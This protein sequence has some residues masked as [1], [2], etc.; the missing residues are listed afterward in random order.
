MYMIN[1]LKS[2]IHKLIIHKPIVHIS[3][4]ETKDYPC[5]PGDAAPVQR[6]PELDARPG[7]H[8]SGSGQAPVSSPGSATGTG[9]SLARRRRRRAPHPAALRAGEAWPESEGDGRQPAGNAHAH[10]GQDTAPAKRPAT[11]IFA[12]IHQ[13]CVASGCLS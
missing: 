7:H 10:A 8:Q 12:R 3:P 5:L 11:S 2:C 1:V 6:G 4:T 9:T 13:R